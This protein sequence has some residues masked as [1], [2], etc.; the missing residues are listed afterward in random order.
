MKFRM[1]EPQQLV[2]IVD[3][4]EKVGGKNS[5]S[6]RFLQVPFNLA[7]D[8]LFIEEKCQQVELESTQTDSLI[9]IAAEL[10]VNILTG[11]SFKSGEI[12]RDK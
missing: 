2:K 4:A 8:Q 11:N 12:L 9:K 5:N 6:F 10:G 7:D 1:F 3:I